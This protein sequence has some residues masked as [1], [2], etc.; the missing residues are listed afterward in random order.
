MNAQTPQTMNH[1]ALR[2][3][4]NDDIARAAHLDWVKAGKPSD[5]HKQFWLEAEA[6]LR[7]LSAA[8]MGTPVVKRPLRPSRA[9]IQVER[10]S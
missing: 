5:C 10:L 6:R 9:V 3:P 1:L 2:V 8:S 7:R 4:T